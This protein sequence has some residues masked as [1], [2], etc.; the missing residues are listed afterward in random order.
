MGGGDGAM[1]AGDT[2]PEGTPWALKS[3]AEP[4]LS[5]RQG[6]T[7]IPIW[8]KSSPGAEA[9]YKAARGLAGGRPLGVS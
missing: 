4:C 1:P 6:R 2:L 7:Q 9:G 5:P 3:A 8:L